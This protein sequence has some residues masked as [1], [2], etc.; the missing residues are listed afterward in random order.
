MAF[1]LFLAFLSLKYYENYNFKENF[2]NES[3][4][5]ENV[6]GN[7]DKKIG[8]DSE[9]VKDENF[10]DRDYLDLFYTDYNINLDRILRAKLDETKFRLVILLNKFALGEAKEIIGAERLN[11]IKYYDGVKIVGD[12]NVKHFDFYQ[13]LE[14]EF[15][16]PFPGKSLNYQIE[17]V[18]DFIDDNTKTIIFW[19]GYNI[20]TFENAENY[21]NKYQ[22]L[23]DEVKKVKPDVDV[24]VCSLMPATEYA[25][26][27]DFEGEIKHNIYRGSEYDKALENHFG[28]KYINIKFL[29]KTD[30]Y[31]SDGIHFMPRFYYVFVP[32]LAYYLNLSF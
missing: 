24:Y 32:Y 17:H 9:S 31:G 3:V 1:F 26:K 8:N 18:K 19:N 16:Y 29:A 27:R 7:N 25:I 12:S 5:T 4:V 23:F 6:A 21:V 22:E 15:Y 2:S 20:A 11:Y 10:A 14:K 30:F 13:V 28:D